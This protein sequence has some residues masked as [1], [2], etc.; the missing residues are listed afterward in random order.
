MKKSFNEAV[1][2]IR[3][4]I[5]YSPA[6]GHAH[7]VAAGVGAGAYAYTGSAVAALATGTMLFFAAM[8][9]H[10]EGRQYRENKGAPKP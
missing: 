2:V 4:G 3:D 5:N 10:Y 9:Y 6:F 7:L 1:S 8:G